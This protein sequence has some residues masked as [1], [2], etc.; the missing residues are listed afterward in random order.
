MGINEK[1]QI[2]CIVRV[3][4]REVLGHLVLDW[5]FLDQC[6]TYEHL[7]VP[8]VHRGSVSIAWLGDVGSISEKL[9][10]RDL[11]LSEHLG[12]TLFVENS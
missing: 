5:R 12:V 10:M 9:E 6:L 2:V 7:C 3:R 4:G 1:L 11:L 8:A